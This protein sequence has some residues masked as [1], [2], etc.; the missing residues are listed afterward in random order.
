[1]LSA[2]GFPTICRP[3]GRTSEVNP[4][5][6]DKAGVLAKLNGDVKLLLPLKPSSTSSLLVTPALS[7][8]LGA[9]IEDVGITKTSTL[10]QATRICFLSSSLS[11]IAF[12]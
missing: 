2:N 12:R 11:F 10:V 1:M 5:H 7:G 6:M 9:G 3:T 8:I 4:Q